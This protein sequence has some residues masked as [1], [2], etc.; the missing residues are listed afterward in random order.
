LVKYHFECGHVCSKDE[1]IKYYSTIRC[2]ID[3]CKLL[4]KTTHCKLCGKEFKLKRLSGACADKCDTCKHYYTI[5]DV[6]RL[7]EF[8]IKDIELLIENGTITFNED[9]LIHKNDY[10]KFRRDNLDM[11]KDGDLSVLTC[12]RSD[13]LYKDKC[14]KKDY[15]SRCD[16]YQMNPK[17]WEESKVNDSGYTCYTIYKKSIENG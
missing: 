3:K 2:P 14:E 12:I 9:G 8:S 5:E 7:C 4:F 11:I 10:G 1:I 6:S 15:V 17:Y 16:D 13:C